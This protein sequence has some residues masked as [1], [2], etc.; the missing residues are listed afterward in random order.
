[1]IIGEDELERGE[2][3]VKDLVSGEQKSVALERL[4][5]AVRA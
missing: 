5:E 4:A 3:A 1:M 2:A